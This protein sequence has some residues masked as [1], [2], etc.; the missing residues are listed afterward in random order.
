MRFEAESP[1]HLAEYRATVEEAV[2]AA[3][4]TVERA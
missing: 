3:R 4:R 1:G 2:A